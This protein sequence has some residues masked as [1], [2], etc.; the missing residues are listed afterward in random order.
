M[1]RGLFITLEGGEGAGKSTQIKKLRAWLEA[2]GHSLVQTREP[3]GTPAGEALRECFIAHQGQDWPIP[4]Q[5]L[6]MFTGR[7]LHVEQVIRP[8]IESGQIVICDRFT[9]STRAYQGYALGHDLNEIEQIRQ[10]AIGDFEPDLTFIFDIDPREG[11][12]RTGR[13]QGRG[14]TFENHDLAFH[15]RL[16]QGFL[17]IALKN[18]GRCVKLDATQPIDTVTEQVRKTVAS[19]LEE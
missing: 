6:F 8:A 2:E 3:G 11:L 12:K 19:R 13:R 17:E 14:D 9:D 7:A 10:I 18:P 15:D 16:R 5:L 4:A 1:R